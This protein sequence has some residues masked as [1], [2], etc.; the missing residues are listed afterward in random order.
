MKKK[1]PA[2][3]SW[4]SLMPINLFFLSR[5]VPKCRNIVRTPGCEA[6]S[7]SGSKIE[8]RSRG[9]VYR[10]LRWQ[11]RVGTCSNTDDGSGGEPWS[12]FRWSARFSQ[13]RDNLPQ[14]CSVSAI[15][16]S[17]RCLLTLLRVRTCSSSLSAYWTCAQPCGG[18]RRCA[19]TTAGLLDLSCLQDYIDWRRVGE[20]CATHPTSVS[21]ITQVAAC[22][23][24]IIFY[25]P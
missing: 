14:A 20:H 22:N 8:G 9:L 13:R 11:S 19:G 2:L 4:I 12:Y 15:H 18:G 10:R 1:D 24:G 7:W 23:P 6:G 5:F 25:R 17:K 21:M 16:V 3:V